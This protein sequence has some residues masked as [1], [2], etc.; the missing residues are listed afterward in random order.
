MLRSCQLIWE[1]DITGEISIPKVAEVNFFFTYMRIHTRARTH[2]KPRKTCFLYERL[3]L[4]A[5]TETS[6]S[7]VFP[8]SFA[9]F[10]FGEP[11]ETLWVLLK[12]WC[13]CLMEAT[14]SSFLINASWKIAVSLIFQCLVRVSPA[15]WIG[16][17]RSVGWPCQGRRSCQ[18]TLSLTPPSCFCWP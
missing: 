13:R 4:T 17:L 11:R 10:G 7:C 15:A 6:F 2:T 12:R 5:N 9:H 8:P 14:I 16:E 3:V 1:V 18:P